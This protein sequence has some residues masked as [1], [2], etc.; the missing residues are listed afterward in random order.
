MTE[1]ATLY[2][3]LPADMRSSG[4]VLTK[5]GR[6][7][8]FPARRTRTRVRNRRLPAVTQY[9]RLT[10]PRSYRSRHQFHVPTRARTWEQ[11]VDEAVST[12][13]N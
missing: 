6:D 7:V 8:R 9:I 5:T 4:C 11:P 10:I 12:S 13:E 1:P 2:E 3:R